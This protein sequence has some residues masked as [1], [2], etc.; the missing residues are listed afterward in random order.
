MDYTEKERKEQLKNSK[1][2]KKFEGKE[3]ILF[4][5]FQSAGFLDSSASSTSSSTDMTPEKESGSSK[6]KGMQEIVQLFFA[7]DKQR[8]Q[9][10]TE[11]EELET[12]LD[13]INKTLTMQQ[14]SHQQQQ[15]AKNN[16]DPRVLTIHPEDV[17]DQYT[18]EEKIKELQKANEE[19]QEIII[20]QKIDLD[21]QEKKLRLIRLEK[22]EDEKKTIQQ[23]K[24]LNQ[25][26]QT[27]DNLSIE[28]KARPTIKQWNTKQREIADLEEVLHNT[29][30]SRQESKELTSWKKYLSTKEQMN[31]D[32]KNHSL[33]LWLI[34]SLPKS[35]LKDIM[36][37]VCRELD[38]TDVSEVVHHI[39]KLKTVI[40]TVPRMEELLSNLSSYIFERNSQLNEILGMTSSSSSNE[41]DFSLDSL[42][43]ILRR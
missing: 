14:I 29:I 30:V 28:L 4:S 23:Q 31:I 36:Q 8:K 25:L 19:L 1:I 15:Q 26:K 2:L 17:D 21:Y 33:H 24:E 18:K 6:D 9:L 43:S 22:E 20:Q 32:Q 11:K 5:Y 41:N 3:R 38:V 16:K 40:R 42:L 39:M 12:S 34:E 37:S 35:Y 7:L 27:I 13:K 10:K